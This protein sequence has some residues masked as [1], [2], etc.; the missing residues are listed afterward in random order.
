[1]YQIIGLF[2][3][4][5]DEDE[6]YTHRVRKRAKGDF[7]NGLES[8]SHIESIWGNLKSIIKNIYY[9]IP[10]NNFILFL[11]EAEFRRSISKL[12]FDNK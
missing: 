12:S 9:S 3:I 7:G 10:S 1:M 6:N 5:F 8:M 11:R 2:M 4:G